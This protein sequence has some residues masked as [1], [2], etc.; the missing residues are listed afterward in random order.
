MKRQQTSDGEKE[1]DTDTEPVSHRQFIGRAEASEKM[2]G[3]L[4]LTPFVE[5][6][7]HQL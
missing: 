5:A 2:K 1:S 4:F 3:V 7:G 6:A